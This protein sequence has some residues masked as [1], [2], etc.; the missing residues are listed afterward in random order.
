MTNTK[1]KPRLA[2]YRA[3]ACG[4]CEVTLTALGMRLLEIFE[5]ADVVF[6]PY[7]VDCRYSDVEALDEGAIDVCFFNGAIQSSEDERVARLLRSKSR[8]LVAFGACAHQGGVLGLANL[9]APASPQPSDCERVR[10]L[11]QVVEV[12]YYTPGC[13]PAA[14][15]AWNVFQTLLNG[16]LPAKG[17]VIGADDKTNCDVCP[18]HK[19]QSGARIREFKRPHL[20]E[21]DPETCFLPQG[22]ICSGPATRAG[23][24]LPCIAAN[25]PCRGCYGPPE[26]VQDQGARLLSAIA[27]LVDADEPGD[28]ERILDSIVDP[29]GTL[30][31]FGLADSTLS[32]LK[33]GQN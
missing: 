15:Q 9:C 8:L 32:E 1:G 3:A 14:E 11:A 26:G 28:V 30:F 4:G 24:G 25:V 27:A 12:D 21:S 18:R 2:F 7:L 22:L 33:Y 29:V 19:G 10:T 6:W 16:K 20:V 5:L 13:P 17:S 31:R 23:C